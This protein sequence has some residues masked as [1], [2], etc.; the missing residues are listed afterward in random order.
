M[1][2]LDEIAVTEVDEVPVVWAAG[3]APLSASLVFRVGQADEAFL[4][5]GVTHL[6]E[7]LVM[8][9][10]GRVPIEANAHVSTHT[11]AFE[12]TGS[13]HHVVAFLASVCEQLGRLDTAALDV[14]RRVLAAEAERGSGAGP[15]AEAAALRYGCRGAGLLAYRDLG[16]PRLDA[17]AVAAWAARWFTRGN[18][19]LALTGPVPEDLRLPLPP[20]ERAA[21]APATRRAL[22]L[23]AW[24]SPA[25]GTAVSLP[26]A[27]GDGSDLALARLLA[28][29]AEDAVRHERGLAYDVDTDVLLVD[30]VTS[31]VALHADNDPAHA[32][33]VA[34]LL[35][36]VLER[37]AA[38]GPAAQDLAADVAQAFEALADP[39]RTGD[40]VGAAAHELLLGLPLRTPADRY[41]QTRRRSAGQLREAVRAALGAAVVLLPEGTAFERAGLHRLAP[42]SHPVPAGRELRP[43]PFRGV[44]R[45]TRLV[46][47]EDGV[48]LRLPEGDVVARWDDVVGVTV[49]AD[50]THV[51]QTG[52]GPAVPVA[53]GDFRGAGD[54][55]VQLRRRLPA[56]L[57]VPDPEA[58]GAPAG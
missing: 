31:E 21:V 34:G 14:E 2:P 36:D 13:A 58:A 3:P 24:E 49:L 30:P 23:P 12:A 19:V 39:R 40:A 7:H 20:G 42:S 41:E 47:G 38:D 22:R 25:G 46:V 29:A 28:R 57:F 35:L 32:A 27:A 55:L 18:A 9:G 52:D 48:A 54:V 11:T 43:R 6:V 17:A 16:V 5:G 8:R 33:E 4:D 50:G 26:L 37:F 51:L 15:A 56:A 1:R 53:T 10:V 45:G 44:P